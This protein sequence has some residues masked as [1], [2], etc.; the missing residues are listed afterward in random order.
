[1]ILEESLWP[2]MTRQGFAHKTRVHIKPSDRPLFPVTEEG[3]WLPAVEVSRKSYD[4]AE[5]LVASLDRD[6]PLFQDTLASIAMKHVSF[7][8]ETGC[9]PLEIDDDTGHTEML[10][11]VAGMD[12]RGQVLNR[13]ETKRELQVCDTPQCLNARHFDFTHQVKNRDRFLEVDPRHYEALPDGQIIPVW[14]KG[15][16]DGFVLPSVEA[17]S[18]ALRALQE[19]CVPHI[20]D[21]REAP[22]SAGSVSKI[23]LDPTTGCWVTRTYYNRPDTFEKSFMYD[24]YGRLGFG[25][26]LQAQGVGPAGRFLAHRVT[27]AANGGVLEKGKVLNHECGFHPCCNPGHLRQVTSAENNIH[28]RRMNLAMRALTPDVV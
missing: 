6:I 22:L 2:G 18:L 14:E 4:A 9:W 1:M 16:E 10:W 23:T 3:K 24:G 19:R 12:M 25:P 5:A 28:S 20:D 17:S 26:A 21:P 13:R 7:N 11:Q 27:W 15:F 8:D